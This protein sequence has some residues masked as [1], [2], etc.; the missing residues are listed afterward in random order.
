M[1]VVGWAKQQIK[2]FKS[3]IIMLAVL[4]VICLV[5]GVDF[6]MLGDKRVVMMVL[7]GEPPS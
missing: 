6:D 7:D 1:V 5:M 2:S 3:P 4:V